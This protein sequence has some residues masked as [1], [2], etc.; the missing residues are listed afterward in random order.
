MAS[1]SPPSISRR[2]G[3]LN[4]YRAIAGLLSLLVFVQAV[5]AGQAQFGEWAFEIHGYVGNA[6]F[7]LAVIGPGLAAAAR[8]RG[9]IVISG[10]LVVAMFAQ[11]GPGYVGRENAD[12]AATHIPLGVAIF[13]LVIYQVILARGAPKR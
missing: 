4:G 9:L 7:L 3:L 5:I 2:A 11:T 13:G 6:S 1:S 8:A 12:A 10:A